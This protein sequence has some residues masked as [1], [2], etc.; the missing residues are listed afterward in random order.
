M[1]TIESVYKDATIRKAEGL[2]ANKY[3][4]QRDAQDP[5]VWWVKGSAGKKYRV[6]VIVAFDEDQVSEG[7]PDRWVD[8]QL[9]EGVK[10]ETGLEYVSCTCPNGMNRGGRPTCYHTAAV[11]IILRD[12]KADE[13]PVM[14]STDPHD[15]D[16]IRDDEVASLK[17]QG[18]TDEEIEFLRS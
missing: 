17:A 2:L 10:P 9:V 8:G 4:V 15:E 16:F 1:D 6:Q 3:A 12:G 18:Y 11:L 13:H 7:T 5:M 14:E